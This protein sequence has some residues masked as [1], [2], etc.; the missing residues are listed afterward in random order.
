M[1]TITYH[2]LRL[3]LPSTFTIATLGGKKEVRFQNQA[4]GYLM[5]INSKGN[6][7]HVTEADWNHANS[8]RAHNPR[9]PWKSSLYSE[10]SQFFSYGLNHA[11][12]LLCAIEEG[13]LLELDS[14]AA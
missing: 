11:A 10:L 6:S 7:Y 2:Q 8:I 9:N 3:L 14:I 13:D 4:G 12:A 5:A 1:P